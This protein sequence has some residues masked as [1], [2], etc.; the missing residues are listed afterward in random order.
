MTATELGREFALGALAGRRERF[1]NGKTSPATGS[2][3]K[4]EPIPA[5]MRH[6]PL[7]HRGYPVPVIVITGNDGKPAFTIN[8]IDVQDRMVTEDRCAVCGGKL[9]RGRWLVGGCLSALASNG[10]FADTPLHDECAHY[11]L[12]VCPY[13]AAPGWKNPIAQAQRKR[14][15]IGVVFDIE[16]TD[17]NRPQAFIAI[18]ATRVD[19]KGRGFGAYLCRPAEG[20][21][22][23]A[24]VWQNGQRLAGA[25][26]AD[27]RDHARQQV[28]KYGN[29]LRHDIW[30][31]MGGASRP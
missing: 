24:E 8:D 14:A 22:R 26:L 29:G 30:R 28:G 4:A 20:S 21:V 10:A 11:A 5:R 1:A 23:V 18:M 13:L 31:L 16:K 27:F 12:K 7:D 15:G 9:F 17:P 19:I 25:D 2:A 3:M 6:L